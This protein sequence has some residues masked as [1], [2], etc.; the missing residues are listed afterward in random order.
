[1][2]TKTQHRQQQ[3]EG[4]ILGLAIG[5]ALGVPYEFLSKEAMEKR[6]ATTMI[7]YGSHNQPAGTWSDDSSLTFCLMEALCDGYDTK[8]MAQKFVDWCDNNHWT[9][10]GRVFDIGM[11]TRQAIYN[12]GQG[13]VPEICGGFDEY[14]NGNGSLMRI[15]PMVFFLERYDDIET[16]YQMV[17]DVSSLTHAHLRSVLACFI[18]LEYARELL[19]TPCKFEAYQHSMKRVRTFLKAKDL[20]PQELAFYFD[21]LEINIKDVEADRIH[22]SGYVVASLKASLWCFLN[23]NTYKDAVLKAVNLGEDTDT[24]AAITGGLAGLHYGL[25]QI[26]K[27]W[28]QQLAKYQAIKALINNFNN[29]IYYETKNNSI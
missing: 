16:R 15:L 19:E 13:H 12:M 17:K 23:T 9:P 28:Q 25:E 20:N 4:A 21:V 8:L 7:G 2:K 5:D 14:S 29:A 10:H 26:P 27:S 11:A 18:Y 1:M 6:P 3:V 22:G 24:T